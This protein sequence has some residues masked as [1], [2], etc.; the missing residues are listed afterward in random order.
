[1]KLPDEYGTRDNYH[2][3]FDTRQ[4]VRD[5]DTLSFTTV[6]FH[7]AEYVFYDLFE[8]SRPRFICEDHLIQRRTGNLEGPQVQLDAFLIRR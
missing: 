3:E 4:R 5:L 8:L 2:C 7:P 6:S 1:M